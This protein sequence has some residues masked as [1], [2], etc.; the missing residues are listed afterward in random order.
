VYADI[1]LLLLDAS[2]SE[3]QAQMEVCESLLSEL[4]AGEKPKLYV[5]NKC[6]RM[7]EGAPT[8]ATVIKTDSGDR[9]VYISAL[10]GEGCAEL[11]LQIRDIIRQGKRRV[12][13]IIPNA[14][15]GALSKLYSEQA[16]VEDVE[17]GYESVRVVATV[18][19][20]VYGLMRK[21]DPD[22]KAPTEDF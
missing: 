11:C 7:A 21:Y 9:V 17:Y 12:T 4:G 13:F 3:C 1:I 22:Y 18:D 2:D 19:D 14:E 8:P 20:R 15:Q 10:T 6:D 5:F 16:S